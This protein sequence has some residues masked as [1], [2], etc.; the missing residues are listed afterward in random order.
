M[1]NRL[2]YAP[3]GDIKI[4][5]IEHIDRVSGGAE[6][7]LLKSLEEPLPYRIVIASTTNKD[8]LL[9]TILSRALLIHC[10]APYAPSLLSEERKAVF[11]DTVEALETQNIAVLSKVAAKV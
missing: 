10:D 9:P 7:A 3:A 8:L 4:L 6:N 2:S 11:A 1:N 5:L